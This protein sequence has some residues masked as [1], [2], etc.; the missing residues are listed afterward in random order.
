MREIP[1]PQVRPGNW[2]GALIERLEL[3]G[4][5]VWAVT[6]RVGLGR[7]PRRRW[8]PD[9]AMAISHAADQPDTLGLP[10]LDLSDGAGDE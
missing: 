2:R 10:L 4:S 9:H 6:V 1:I 8:F 3:A 5:I 7:A